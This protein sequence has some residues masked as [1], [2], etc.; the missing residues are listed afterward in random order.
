MRG[1]EDVERVGVDV[2]ERLLG[3]EIDVAVEIDDEADVES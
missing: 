3:L 2:S 1:V